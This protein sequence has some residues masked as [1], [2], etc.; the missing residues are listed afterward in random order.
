VG[1]SVCVLNFHFRGHKVTPV[2]K[3]LKTLLFISEKDSVPS[4]LDVT[5]FNNQLISHAKKNMHIFSDSNNYALDDANVHNL[6]KSTR[7]MPD[8]RVD[9]SNMPS[10]ML[11]KTIITTS[12]PS[13]HNAHRLSQQQLSSQPHSPKS[14]HNVSPS[15]TPSRIRNHYIN[16]VT[17]DMGRNA[18]RSNLYSKSMYTFNLG[19]SNEN[20]LKEID[21]THETPNMNSGRDMRRS[22]PRIQ[23]GDSHAAAPAARKDENNMEMV[24]KLMKKTIRLIEKSK[25]KNNTMQLINDDWKEVASRVDLILFVIACSIVTLCPVFLFGKFFIQDNLI[26]AAVNKSCGCA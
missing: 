25:L 17:F 9:Q 4:D 3:W 22:V 24:I 14:Q 21:C 15:A 6:S 5:A 20:M 11:N 10:Y 2:P 26:G 23:V 18:T 7:D 13:R 19:D 12:I 16:E 8:I 1:T